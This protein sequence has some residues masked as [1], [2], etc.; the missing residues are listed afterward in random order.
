MHARL[1]A[2]AVCGLSKHSG[3]DCN[4]AGKERLGALPVLRVRLG[5]PAVEDG[6]AHV[7]AENTVRE[8]G[9]QQRLLIRG[10]VEGSGGVDAAHGFLGEPA[11]ALALLPMVVEVL[12][13]PQELTVLPV[14]I[15]AEAAGGAGRVDLAR[16]G[17]A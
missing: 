3:I 12:I 10:L 8:P 16:D 7:V 2:P 14:C 15:D 13:V 1:G 11:G 6:L 17:C 4:R 5:G 9:K